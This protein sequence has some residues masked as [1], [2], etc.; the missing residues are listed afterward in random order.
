MDHKPCTQCAEVQPEGAAPSALAEAADGADGMLAVPKP[1]PTAAEAAKPA[2]GLKRKGFAVSGCWGRHGSA[3]VSAAPMWA[4]RPISPLPLHAQA[5]RATA[6]PIEPEPAAPPP[7]RPATAPVK[8]IPKVGAADGCTAVELCSAVPLALPSSVH[9]SRCPC[10]AVQRRLLSLWTRQ[11]TRRTLAASKV[12]ARSRQLKICWREFSTRD[13][14]Q[15]QSCL[16]C[17][18]RPAWRLRPSPSLRCPPKRSASPS[19][20][21]P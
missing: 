10:R 21:W 4:H 6:A 18:Q 5:P 13:E 2:M 17:A 14:L 12:G 3:C 16:L 7:A 20:Q 8:K 1:A 19:R 15:T 9:P 11:R